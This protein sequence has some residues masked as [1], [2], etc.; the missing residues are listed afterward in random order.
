MWLQSVVKLKKLVTT[1]KSMVC[2]TKFSFLLYVINRRNMIQRT[3]AQVYSF[4]FL[5]SRTQDA[6]LITSKL[7]N[8]A[9]KKTVSGRTERF[10]EEV[11]ETRRSFLRAALGWGH[12]QNFKVERVSRN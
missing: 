10:Y 6:A 4:K 1:L 9:E 7:G 5:F 8:P 11:V 2:S 12:P 3:E